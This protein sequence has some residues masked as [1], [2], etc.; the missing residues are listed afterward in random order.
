MKKKLTSENILDHLWTLTNTLHKNTDEIPGITHNEMVVRMEVINNIRQFV[1]DHRGMLGCED[2][3]MILQFKDDWEELRLKTIKSRKEKQQDREDKCWLMIRSL[4]WELDGDYKRCA[5]EL[6]TRFTSTEVND[7]EMFVDSKQK[8]LMF[9]FKEDWLSDPG[10]DVSDDGWN[11]LTAE[12]VGRGKEFYEDITVEKLQQMAK[13][14]D[15]KE[16][17]KY[18]F[19]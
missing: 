17:F 3:D 12:V 11:D 8:S 5:Y 16:N 10:I 2:E 13:E 14:F 19:H 6:K 1:K 15:Y 9:L 4:D 18:S 7:L